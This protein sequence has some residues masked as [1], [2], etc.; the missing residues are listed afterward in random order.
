MYGDVNDQKSSIPGFAGLVE[1]YRESK[2][3]NI[4]PCE[5]LR[6]LKSLAKGRGYEYQKTNH[7][8]ITTTVHLQ[9]GAEQALCK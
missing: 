8:S 3:G 4:Q 7:T 6:T 5:H 9:D 1:P 2:N